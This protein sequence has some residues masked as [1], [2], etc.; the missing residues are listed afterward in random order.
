MC[1]LWLDC[2]WKLPTIDERTFL[3]LLVRCEHAY[4]LDNCTHDKFLGCDNGVEK[5][6]VLRR[7][8]LKCTEEEFL[9]LLASG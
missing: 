4:M 2:G 6:G 5:L 9:Q 3:G 8:Q 7:G 1:D